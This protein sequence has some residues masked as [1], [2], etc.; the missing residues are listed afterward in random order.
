MNKSKIA[1]IIAG[2]V[3]IFLAIMW[4]W[5]INS[6]DYSKM[7]ALNSTGK[8]AVNATGEA[9]GGAAVNATGGAAGGAAK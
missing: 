3:M 2:I 7:K 1:P 6:I 5:M 9:A 8:A 4:A